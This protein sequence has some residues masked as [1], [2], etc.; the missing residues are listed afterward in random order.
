VDSDE[1]STRASRSHL[2]RRSNSRARRLAAIAGREC[3]R[4]ESRKSLVRNG[5]LH[6]RIFVSMVAP[7]TRAVSAS[8]RSAVAHAAFAVATAAKIF[9]RKTFRWL[10][11]KLREARISRESLAS[12]SPLR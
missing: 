9:L 2:D 12:D 1:T 6:A 11:R 10:V 7:A 8:R 5:F 3:P 4:E